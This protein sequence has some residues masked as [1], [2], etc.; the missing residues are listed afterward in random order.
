MP[1]LPVGSSPVARATPAQAPAVSTPVAPQQQAA[2]TKREDGFDASKP[3]P[4]PVV[5]QP[6]VR[7]ADGLKS[8]EELSPK[9]QALL[10]EDGKARW[11]ALSAKE[12]AGFIVLTTRM[13]QNKLD[14]SGLKLKAQPEGIQQDR[15]LFEAEPKEAVERLKGQVQEAVKRGDFLEDKPSGGLHGDGMADYGARQWVTRESMQ[16]GF[17][18]DGLFVDIDRFGVKTDL[19]GLFGHFGEVIHNHTT[20]SKTDPFKVGKALHIDVASHLPQSAQ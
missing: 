11:D 5:T 9:Q 10:G 13:E 1:S 2:A 18:K 3:R 14:S 16:L 15:L 19:V 20:S 12:K 7:P 4:A 6:G 17:G 8:Y